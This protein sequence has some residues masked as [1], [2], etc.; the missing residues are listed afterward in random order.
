MAKTPET[1]CKTYY[2]C[3]CG[4]LFLERKNFIRH[5]MSARKETRHIRHKFL[6]RFSS[7]WGR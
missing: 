4:L 1:L 7:M 2:A 3:A 5:R 6:G